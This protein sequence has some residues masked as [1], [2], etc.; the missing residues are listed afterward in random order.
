MNF[1]F[2]CG[3]ALLLYHI[4]DHQ[5]LG[6]GFVAYTKTSVADGEQVRRRTS[7]PPIIEPEQVGPTNWIVQFRIPFALIEKYTGPLGD[8]SGAHWRANFYKCGDRTS[9][10][11]WGSWSPVARFDFHQPACFGEIIFDPGS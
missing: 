9:H 8:I 4:T 10:P 7:L 6:D 5:R 3:G 2:N 11:H 1:E